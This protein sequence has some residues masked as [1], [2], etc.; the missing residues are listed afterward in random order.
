MTRQILDKMQNV[1]DH[2]QNDYIWDHGEY[3][4]CSESGGGCL[5][6]N[7]DQKAFEYAQE[8]FNDSF[9]NICID[10]GFIDVDDEK[11]FESNLKD[12]KKIALELK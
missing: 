8:K 5:T 6:H 3:D 10:F 1:F 2:F 4:H 12:L 9:E 7:S 11:N